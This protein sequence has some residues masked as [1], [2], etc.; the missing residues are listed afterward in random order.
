MQLAGSG[1]LHPVEPHRVPAR[2]RR[3]GAHRPPR[4]ARP[5]ARLVLGP[6]AS[7]MP[8]RSVACLLTG[9]V[10]L[11]SG[12]NHGIGAATAG[13]A[14][15]PRRR[16]RRRPTSPT[17][18]TTTRTSTGPTAYRT[19]REQGPEA[20]VRRRSR[21]T[22][23]G[24]VAVSDDL[25]DPAVAG[26]HLR[27]RRGGAR[28]RC[29]SSSTTPAAG[30]RTRSTRA[31]SNEVGW[32]ELGDRPRTTVDAQ[33]PGR[34]PRR[35]ALDDRR[36]LGPPPP[37]RAA[38]T[39]AGSSSLHVRR[40]PM[41]LPRPGVATAHAQGARWTNYTMAGVD[42]AGRRRRSSANVVY[43][44][45]DRHRLG[46]RRRPRA[47]SPDEPRP[48]PRRR[49]PARGRRGHRA[50]SA[51]TPPA[52]SPATSSARSASPTVRSWR[53]R[54]THGVASAARARVTRARR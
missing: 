4:T 39:G 9:R 33:L 14:G 23:V 51:P 15:P 5:P 20:T 46:H 42:R 47:S 16:R 52:S 48:R 17:R 53:C 30:G 25:S 26:A 24:C 3:A 19:Q 34:R 43:P 6:V 13:R 21:A 37:R 8:I 50:G 1:A 44:P 22:A 32:I 36:E 45:V 35:G 2:R 11:V 41:R 31:G 28:A 40:P 12:A 38:P 18:P 54:V 7:P 27:R 29:R 10:A 49:S